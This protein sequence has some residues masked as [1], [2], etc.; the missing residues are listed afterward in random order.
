MS[1]RALIG[2]AI[3]AVAG[4]SILLSLINRGS[5]GSGGAGDLSGRVIDLRPTV[6]AT[7]DELAF[8]TPQSDFFLIDTVGKMYPRV[9]ADEWQLRIHG[10]VGREVTLTYADLEAMP[11]VEHVVTLGCV[12]NEVGG[13]LIG[14]A[15]WSGVYLAD[16]LSMAGVDPSAEQLVSRSVDGWTCGTPVSAVLDGRP[17]MLATRMNGETLTGEHG[18]PVRMIVPGLF[19]FVSATKWVTDID[20][21][22]WGAFDPYWLQRGWAREAPMLSSSR[23]DVPRAKSQHAAG[24]ITFG[25]FAWAPRAGVGSVQLRVDGGEWTNVSVVERDSGDA[26]VLW[27]GEVDVAAGDHEV[28]AR[29]VDAEGVAQDEATREVLPSGATGLHRVVISVA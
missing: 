25:G 1:R 3:G 6:P 2:S 21:T 28:E 22:T 15:R 27:R 14:T 11:Q 18:F 19:G 5:G 7:V 26:W 17:A 4:G 29:V 9:V 16:V 20:V 12:S 13:D 23:I 8:L 24:A 10:M